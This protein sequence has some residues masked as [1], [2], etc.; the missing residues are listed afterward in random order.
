[1]GV[2]LF[3]ETSFGNRNGGEM[4]ENM[5]E[6]PFCEEKWNI[7]GDISI[8]GFCGETMVVDEI[9]DIE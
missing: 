5:V 4:M 2:P 8:C 3:Q 6:Y 7:L 1:L 9:A